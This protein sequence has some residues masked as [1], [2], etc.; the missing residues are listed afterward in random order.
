M[1][2][3][4]INGKTSINGKWINVWDIIASV[5]GD[6]YLTEKGY[7]IFKENIIEIRE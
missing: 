2:G 6:I 5:V 3:Q 1:Q 4:A 7:I